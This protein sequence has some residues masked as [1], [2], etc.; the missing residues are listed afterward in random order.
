MASHKKRVYLSLEKK[1]GTSLKSLEMVFV[2]GKT[3]ISK[4]LKNK[5]SILAEMLLET[6]YTPTVRLVNLNILMSM[7]LSMNGLS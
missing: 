7:M 6:G 1:V 3:Q 5:E 4:I 2:C